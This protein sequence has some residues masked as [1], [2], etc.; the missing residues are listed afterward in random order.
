MHLFSGSKLVNVRLVA[1]LIDSDRFLCLA[2]QTT[3]VL[4]HVLFHSLSGEGTVVFVVNTACG[5]QQN[6]LHAQGATARPKERNANNSV[7]CLTKVTQTIT[8]CYS[9]CTCV[10]L[11]AHGRNVACEA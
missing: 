1:L 6:A 7:P 2:A 10:K 3:G 4:P 8:Y 11:V 5:P 9:Y